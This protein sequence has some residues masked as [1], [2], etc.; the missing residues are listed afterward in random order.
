MAV[1][2]ATAQTERRRDT[3]ECAYG[4]ERAHSKETGDFDD[5]LYACAIDELRTHRSAAKKAAAE[6]KKEAT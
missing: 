3:D 1:A 6:E 5:A 2:R 4:Y